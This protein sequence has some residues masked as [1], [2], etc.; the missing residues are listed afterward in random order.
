MKAVVTAV[1]HDGAQ[2]GWPG[3]RVIRYQ[4][5][6]GCWAWVPGTESVGDVIEV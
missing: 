3:E 2:W 1:H 5:D 4:D 6:E